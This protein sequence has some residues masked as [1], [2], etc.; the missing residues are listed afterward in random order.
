MNIPR[1]C[2]RSRLCHDCMDELECSGWLTNPEP[3]T[4]QRGVCERCGKTKSVTKIYRYTLTC[5][6]R[7]RRGM[8]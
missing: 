1:G 2:Y 6:E 4:L 3:D 7:A 5:R 8:E